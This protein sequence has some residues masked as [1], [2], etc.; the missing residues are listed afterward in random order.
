MCLELVVVL[1]VTLKRHLSALCNPPK[2]GMRGL[3]VYAL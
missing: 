1:Q 3:E 2:S